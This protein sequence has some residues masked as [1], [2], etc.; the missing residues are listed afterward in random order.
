[1]ELPTYLP[2]YLPNTPT[3]DHVHP[4]YCHSTIFIQMQDE[5]CSLNLVLKYAS[6]SYICV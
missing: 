5:I 1:M 3:S 6:L 2:T 4:Y